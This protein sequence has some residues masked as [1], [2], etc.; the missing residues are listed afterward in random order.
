MATASA[1]LLFRGGFPTPEMADSIMDAR[2]F[3]RATEAY[4]FFY[5]TVSM[6]AVMQGHRDAGVED[7]C[8][9]LLMLCGPRH[10]LFTGSSDAPYAGVVIDLAVTGPVVV[11]LPPGAYVGGINDHNGRWTADLGRHGADGGR[12]GCYLVLPPGFDGEQPPG[13]HVVRPVTNSVLV[14]VRALALT[15]D[16]AA[17]LDTL[18]RLSVHRL[19]DPGGAEHMKFVDVS[20]QRVDLTPLRWESSLLFWTQL[21]KVIEQETVVD[22]FRPMYGLLAALGIEKGRAFAPD[23]RTNAILRRAAIAGR[24]QMLL[25]SFGSRREDRIVWPD[26]RWE[27]PALRSALGDFELSTAVD[28]EARDRWFAH[29]VGVTR[30]MFQRSPTADSVSWMCVCSSDGEY[31]DGGRKYKLTLPQPVPARLFWSVTAY[32]AQT[33]SQIRTAEDRAVLRSAR[34]L[35]LVGRTKPLELY[36]GPHAPSRGRHRWVKTVPGRGFFA[37]LRLHGP[38]DDAFG[39]S[40]RPGDFEELVDP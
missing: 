13:Y 35:R 23:A 6:E 28:V 16:F 5:P 7:G 10:L 19:A 9:A 8:A 24:E 20:D 30:A 14:V 38:E 33:R 22:E 40:W 39:E 11:D 3:S 4:R 25:A 32:D 29:A 1:E 36:F 31:L 18:R 27:W 26:R 2:D 34:E 21:H 37:Y 17:A 12:G 15:G